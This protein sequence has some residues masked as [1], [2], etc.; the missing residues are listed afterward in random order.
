MSTIPASQTTS[1]VSPTR[2]QPSSQ[3]IAM[4]V[5]RAILGPLGSLKLAVTLF[6]LAILLIFVG[7]LA[8]VER[9]IWEVLEIYFKSW[10]TWIDVMVLFPRSWFPHLTPE[11]ARRWFVL[12]TLGGG[13]AAAL[14]LWS[15]SREFPKAKWLAAITFGLSALLATAAFLRGGFVFPGGATIGALMGVNLLAAHLTR[16]SIQSSG[17]RRTLGFAV[18]ALGLFLTWLVIRSGHNADGF[19]GAPPFSWSTLWTWTKLLLAITSVGLLVYALLG[20]GQKKLLRIIWGSTGVCLSLFT[21][22]LVASGDRTY[23]GDSGMRV[24]WQ[25]MLATLA[26]VVLL[27]GCIPLFG[28]RAGVVVLHSGIGLMMF[29]Q[30]FVGTYDSEGQISLTEGQTTNFSQDIRSVE[31]A[32]TRPQ[33][34]EF[35]GQDDVVVFPVTRN[36]HETNLLNAKRLSHAALPFDVEIVDYLK[37]SSV[38][39]Q[40]ASGADSQPAVADAGTNKEFRIVP[41]KPAT[42]T[43]G[44]GIDLASGYFRLLDKKTGEA[45]ETYLLSQEVLGMRNGQRRMFDLEQ[46]TW[47]GVPYRLQLRF[48]RSYKDYRITLK[49][50]EKRDYLGTTIPRDYSSEIHLVDSKRNV[51]QDLKIWMNNPQRYAGETFYQ[52][53]YQMDAFQ[54]EYS[55]LQ[56]VRNYGWMIPYAS[57]MICLVGMA[58]H[59]FFSLVRF[60]DRQTRDGAEPKRRTRNSEAATSSW[61]R[62]LLVPALVLTAFTLLVA[63]SARLPVAKESAMDLAAFGQ[64]PVIYQGRVQPFDSLARNA[65]RKLSDS[66]TMNSVKPSKQLKEEWKDIETRLKARFPKIAGEDLSRFQTGDAAG[67]IRLIEEKSGEDIYPIATV[68]QKQMYTRQPAV[69]WLL[70]TITGSDASRRHPVIRIYHPQILAL[71]NLK[72]RKYYRYSLEEIAPRMDAFQ[73]QIVQAEQIQREDAGKLSLY[74]RKLLEVDGKLRVILALHRAFSPPEFPALPTAEEFQT[75]RDAARQKIEAFRTAME[76]QEDAFRAIQPPLSIPPSNA[77]SEAADFDTSKRW[78]AYASAWPVQVLKTRLMG[79]PMDANFKS[80]ND[81][82]LSYL[83]SDATKFNSGVAAYAGQLKRN[84][85]ADLVARP[86]VANDFVAGRYGSFYEFE[87]VYNQAAP[88]RWCGG[89]YLLAFAVLAVGW[90]RWPTLLNRC[91]F[92]L[93]VATFAYHSLAIVARIYLSGRPPVTNLYSSAIF[94]GWGIVGLA[95]LIEYFYRNG[96]ATVVGSLSGFITLTIADRLA[97]DGDTMQVLQAVLDTQFWLATHVVCVTFGYATTF[98]AG[99]FGLLYVV[100]GVFTPTLSRE[101]SA[102]LARMIYGSLCFA[103]FFSFIGTVLGGLWADESWGRFWGWDPKENGALIIVLWNALVLHARWDGMIRERGMAVLSLVGN[104]V[105]AW[106]WFGV[107][108]LGVGLHSYGFTEGVLFALACAIGAHL[109]VI[110]LGCLPMEA[111]WSHRLRRAG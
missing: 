3:T 32:V 24:L 8:Q 83:D 33:S 71:L 104:I 65:L 6:A 15:N 56:V 75:N 60:L 36:G 5:Q 82:M 110:G 64:L 19:Q 86:S 109:V 105:T 107:N 48:E 21:L 40:G 53:G 79:M 42:G 30:W 87:S 95:L 70:D 88:F 2:S 84:P 41:A 72:P 35:S 38:S 76:E 54:R 77:P 108:E 80:L 11:T 69:Q 66:E 61:T 89:F 93:V 58:Y 55:T 49:N 9:D 25:L 101:A 91:A 46:V 103:I 1:V 62:R 92:W 44:E 26:G 98:L 96:L 57:C 29:G 106:S 47:N 31:L 28:R 52:S 100:R 14:L 59:F 18:S 99:I 81:I 94:I 63:R 37:S 73:E 51:D 10:T 23:L 12:G 102:D 68:V 45:K 43:S 74:Q 90:L 85:P 67:L 13:T 27:L 17:T 4:R 20:T 16:Y 111:W 34:A 7:T 22:W 50:V 78:V 39:M 97:A